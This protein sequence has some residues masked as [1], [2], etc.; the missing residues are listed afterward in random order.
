[1]GQILRKNPDDGELDSA[2]LASVRK[3][4]RPTRATRKSCSQQSST[5]EVKIA[6]EFRRGHSAKDSLWRGVR[7]N[8]S[9]GQLLVEPKARRKCWAVPMEDWFVAVQQ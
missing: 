3:P 8:I 4:D 5:L 9:H 1:M 7:Y 6:S 2:L